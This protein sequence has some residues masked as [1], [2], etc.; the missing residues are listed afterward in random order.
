MPS[1]K[2][3]GFPTYEASHGIQGNNL[4]IYNYGS[5]RDGRDCSTSKMA[6]VQVES[7]IRLRSDS[8]DN[9]LEMKY[10]NLLA[11]ADKVSKELN[12]LR[13]KKNYDQSTKKK[14]ENFSN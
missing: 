5:G 10:K 7:Q 3:E 8:R 11:E 6:P 13:D 9:M 1:E 12:F 4:D 2:H 14:V